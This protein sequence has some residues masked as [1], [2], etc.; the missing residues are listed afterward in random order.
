MVLPSAEGLLRMRSQ[1]RAI[2]IRRT[3]VTLLP[4]AAMEHSLTGTWELC[5]PMLQVLIAD[6]VE[7]P[8]RPAQLVHSPFMFL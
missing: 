8:H 5:E 1:R 3:F 2:F 6:A 7:D 4:R